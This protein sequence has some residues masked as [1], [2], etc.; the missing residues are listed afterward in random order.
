[1]ARAPVGSFLGMLRK[2]KLLRSSHLRISS[3]YRQVI[4]LADFRYSTGLLQVPITRY[5]TE[6]RRIV[7]AEG[8]RSRP[9]ST[10]ARWICDF[11]TA[12]T[13]RG[14]ITGFLRSLEDHAQRPALEVDQSVLTYADLATRASD[15]AATINGSGAESEP[16]AAVYAYRSV[17]AYAGILGTLMS[18]KG[19]VPLH[20]HF[21]AA[22]T[23]D[24]LSLSGADTVIVGAEAA[25]R[26]PEV[27]EGIDRDLL[28]ICP[29]T[30]DVEPLRQRWNRHR[31]IGAGELIR[32]SSL[33]VPDKV[34]LDACA[35]LLFTS[36]ST[37]R[38]K[39]VPVSQGNVT[40]YLEYISKR[41]DITPEDRASQAFQPTFD[42]SVHDMFVTWGHGACLCSVPHRSLMAPARFI[43]EK[44]LTLWY[45]VP[46]VIMFLSRMHM[47]KPGVFPTLRMSFF[48]GEA[49]PASLAAQWQAAAPNSIVEN[50]YGPTE[51]TIT[52]THYR[53]SPDSMARCRSGNVPM[54][55]VFSTQKA[56][57]VDERLQPVPDG[58]PGELCLSG[59]QVTRAYLNDPQKTASQYVR[60][61]DGGDLIWYRTGDR[62]IRDPDGCIHYLGRIDL[63]VQIRGYRVELQ[64][65]EHVVRAAAG[66]DLAVAVPYPVR[67]GCAEGVH[68]FVCGRADEAVRKQILSECGR[69]LP[70]YMVPRSVRFREAMPLNANGKIDRDVLASSLEK[71]S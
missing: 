70:D 61:P 51:A 54:G 44:R 4:V 18:G 5:A 36:G 46:S 10:N 64:E 49:L 19:Y 58:R 31:F 7:R 17:T 28:L 55:P 16:V 30:A 35:Y 26:L 63:Q 21:P 43:Q 9:S 6:S 20:P 33:I 24:M 53:W 68:V 38:P 71:V 42:V 69:R 13:D 66:G 3:W 2:R 57:V 62:V 11:M 15:L 60:L 65:V 37:G 12:S 39:G 34:D 52:I 14:L 59:S 8:A 50:L 32:S 67:D 41:Y 23:R 25:T 48:A 40:S 47:L 22:R 27:L 1:M 56:A 45:S 29:D